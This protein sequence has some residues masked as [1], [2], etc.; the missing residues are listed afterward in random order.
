MF[1]VNNDDTSGVV[2]LCLLLEHISHHIL[3]SYIFLDQAF[4]IFSDWIFSIITSK[5]LRDRLQISLL[6]L[7]E[8]KGI[9]KLF[10]LK[11]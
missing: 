8:F 2:L 6:I 11:S 7:S 1:K 5:I 4:R 10:P 3:V 9:N